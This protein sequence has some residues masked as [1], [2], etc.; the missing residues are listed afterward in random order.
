MSI[1]QVA[2]ADFQREQALVL[3][4]DRPLARERIEPE[5]D[6]LADSLLLEQIFAG[7]VMDVDQKL[8][9]GSTPK[10]AHTLPQTLRVE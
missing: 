7:T 3:A 10:E 4:G 2:L 5:I 1:A 8:V 6:E 9:S